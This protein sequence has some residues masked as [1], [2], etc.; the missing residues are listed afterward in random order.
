MGSN[1]LAGEAAVLWE[2]T[3]ELFPENQAAF[4]EIEAHLWDGL[5]K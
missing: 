2:K 3:Y 5:R 1:S 4:G